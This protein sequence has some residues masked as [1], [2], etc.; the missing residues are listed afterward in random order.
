LE[1]SFEIKKNISHIKL[2]ALYQII[3]PLQWILLTINHVYFY[4]R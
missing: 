1:Q 2:R 4:L 3:E